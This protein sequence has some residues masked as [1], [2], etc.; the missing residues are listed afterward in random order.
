VTSD[1]AYIRNNSSYNNE[2][3]L[4]ILLPKFNIMAGEALMKLTVGAHVRRVFSCVV[5]HAN[6]IHSFMLAFKSDFKIKQ[7]W[8]LASIVI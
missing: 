5:V 3:K 8:Q 6:D 7:D 4:E 2:L 1:R